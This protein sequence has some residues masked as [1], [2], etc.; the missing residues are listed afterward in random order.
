MIV[1]IARAEFDPARLDSIEVAL[2]A[3]M[4]ASWAESGCLSH[5]MAVENRAEG[6]VSIVERWSTDADLD[7]HLATPN[8]TAFRAAID[9]AVRSIDAKVY[10][11]T[12][13]RPLLI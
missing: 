4:R 10:N 7:A 12:G 3:M 11:V 6:I 13:E 1:V 5:S 9:G 8:M 2:D